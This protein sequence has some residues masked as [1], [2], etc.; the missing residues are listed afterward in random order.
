VATR[1]SVRGRHLQ[2]PRVNW[3]H[4]N[5]WLVGKTISCW[6]LLML[7]QPVV[8]RARHGSGWMRARKLKSR[9][10]CAILS[11]SDQF[12][13]EMSGTIYQ[14]NTLEM[15]KQIFLF[16]RF[17]HRRN[18]DASI[19]S[20]CLACFLTVGSARV[21]VALQDLETDHH[22]ERWRL[23]SYRS[24]PGLALRSRLPKEPACR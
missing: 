14:R 2:A 11:K 1:R 7:S 15:A 20:I 21:D 19:D 18:A 12:C 5:S 13:H 4:R 16:H 24:A 8:F 10:Y 9:P 23:N 6:H 22:C 17:A 3:A